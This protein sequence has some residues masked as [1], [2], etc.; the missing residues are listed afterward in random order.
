MKQSIYNARKNSTL[1]SVLLASLKAH[2]ID[3]SKFDK[4]VLMY[5][6][7]L[8]AVYP[9]LPLLGSTDAKSLRGM[10]ESRALHIR[11]KAL[12]KTEKKILKRVLTIDNDMFI[13]SPESVGLNDRIQRKGYEDKLLTMSALHSQ[14]EYQKIKFVDHLSG[15]RDTANMHMPERYSSDYATLGKV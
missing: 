6:A 14:R 8:K 1:N 11:G 2:P 4:L 12:S 7:A 9:R 10:I 3:S 13:V 15:K 5:S